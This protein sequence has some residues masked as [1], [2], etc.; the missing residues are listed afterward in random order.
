MTDR[1]ALIHIGTHKTATTSLQLFFDL[2]KD[3]L[4]TTGIYLPRAGRYGEL[5]GN[6]GMAWDMIETGMSPEFDKLLTELATADCRTALL[7]SEDFSLLHARP[8]ALQL[9]SD[10][11]RSAGYKPVIAVYLRP[12]AVFAESMYV[13]RVK[14]DYIRPLG[15]YL[16]TIIETGSYIPD[17][18]KIHLIFRYSALLDSFVRA[19]GRENVI[20]RLYEAQ[21]GATHV[22]Q[23][24]LGIFK[25]VDPQF[26]QAPLS[27]QI[28]QPRANDSLHFLGLLYTAYASL[29]KN[30]GR[31]IDVVGTDIIRMVHEIAPAFPEELLGARFS[32]ISRAETLEFLEA[33]GPDNRAIAREYGVEIPFSSLEHVLPEGD[34]AWERARV[35]REVY[36][37]LLD[38]WI[39]EGTGGR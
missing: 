21:R 31:S 32:L 13:E 2:N 25:A 5:S 26:A 20:V 10:G 3:A 22:F 29:H 14:H 37:R 12:Q 39:A 28:H 35:E 30:D 15:Q 11:L 34:P 17:G 18:T 1:V 6:H 33:F 27:L 7:T 38:R 36:D 24:F 8:G 9:M 23:D 19:F 16:R 4:A